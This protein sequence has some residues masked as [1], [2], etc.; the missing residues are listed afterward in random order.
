MHRAELWRKTGFAGRVSAAMLF[1]IKD[2]IFDYYKNEDLG[3]TYRKRYSR[4]KVT[5]PLLYAF[6][7]AGPAEL[8]TYMTLL[9]SKVFTLFR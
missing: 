2:D 5:L 9:R 6:K 1:Q 3:K 4:R 8:E 7:H